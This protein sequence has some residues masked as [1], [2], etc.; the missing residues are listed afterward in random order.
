MNRNFSMRTKA[1]LTMLGVSFVWG[2]TFVIVKNALADIGP[3]LFVGLRFILAFLVLIALSHRDMFKMNLSTLKTGSLLGLFL[4]IGYIFQTLGLK[5]TTSS[6]AGFITGVSVV[7]VPIIYALLNRERPAP[8]TIFIVLLATIGLFLLSVPWGSFN[9]AYG[10]FLVLIGAFGFAL[11]IIYVDRHSHRHNA[12]AITGVQVLFVGLVCLG[13]G[14]TCEPWPSH[15]TFNA[16]LAIVI[17]AVFATA[18]AF[19]AQNYLQR[20]STPT[21]FAVV[22]ASEPVFAALAGYLWAGERLSRQAQIGAA[23]ILAAMLLAILLKKRH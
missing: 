21:D 16:L 19:L 7:L 20:F 22:L 14:L 9:L 1:D 23:L 12:M 13:L 8:R 15:F 11:H 4:F 2:A 10:D 5:A 6:N 17:T 3:F 18:L